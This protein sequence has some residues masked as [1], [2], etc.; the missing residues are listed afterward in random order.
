MKE[1]TKRSK[2]LFIKYVKDAD[3][4]SGTPLVGG[5]VG[6]SKEDRGNLTDL[7]KAG[8]ITTQKDM[9]ASW[10]IFTDK[11][12][13]YAKELG[14]ELYDYKSKTSEPKNKA[15]VIMVNG[16]EEKLKSRP[17]LKE[18]QTIVDGY[19]TYTKAEELSTKKKVILVVDEE[20]LLKG[21][22]PNKGVMRKF[23]RHLVGDVIVLEGWRSVG[24]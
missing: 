15:Y 18:S 4:W 13:E 5:N 24:D 19:I 11:G 23:G 22:T 6:G 17:T 21:K 16:D 1:L 8:L 9:G 10:V 7:K 14:F 2:E 20:G 3:E 12:R